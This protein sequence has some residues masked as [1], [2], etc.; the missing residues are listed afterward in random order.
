MLKSI[1]LL[2]E[3]L[4]QERFSSTKQLSQKI[5]ALLCNTKKNSLVLHCCVLQKDF[6]S[7]SSLYF[8]TAVSPFY[9]AGKGLHRL[10]LLIKFLLFIIN[11]FDLLLYFLSRWWWNLWLINATSAR[12]GSFLFQPFCSLIWLLRSNDVAL[13]LIFILRELKNN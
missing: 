11:R 4:Q 3:G 10:N 8:Y 9:S 1:F 5:S 13:Y 7:I 6:Q 12:A 2:T